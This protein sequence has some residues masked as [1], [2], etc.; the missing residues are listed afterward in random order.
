MLVN[1]RVG[2]AEMDAA[3][4]VARHATSPL[5]IIAPPLGY[6]TTNLQAAAVLEIH[7]LTDGH[8]SAGWVP[9]SWAATGDYA[10]WRPT[11]HL[12]SRSRCTNRTALTQSMRNIWRSVRP[13]AG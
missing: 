4:A 5:P 13:P 7:R 3:C 6:D 1:V 8:Q 12:G 10:S 11:R 2:E 9:V